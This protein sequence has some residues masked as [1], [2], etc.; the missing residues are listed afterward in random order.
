ME[1]LKRAYFKLKSIIIRIYSLITFILITLSKRKNQVIYI[2]AYPLGDTCYAL[3]YRSHLLNRNNCKFY[4]AESCRIMIENCFSDVIDNAAVVYYQKDSLLFKAIR[5]ALFCPWQNRF[6]SKL[7]VKII[8]PYAYLPSNREVIYD[9]F[10]ILK[11]I[12]FPFLPLNASIEFPLVPKVDINSIKDFQKNKKRIVILNPFSNS[13]CDDEKELWEMIADNLFLR[14]YIVYTNVM[15]HQKEVK[16]TKRLECSIIEL[17]NICNEI[18]LFVSVRSGIIDFTISSRCDKVVIW[19]MDSS[20]S[21]KSLKNICN[22]D[23][24]GITNVYSIYHI[25]KQDTIYGFNKYMECF[26][27]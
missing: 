22:L 15:K 10:T 3:A 16:D 17:Y 5:E 19:Y 23:A 12:I 21:L 11:K 9:Y 6:F 4:F 2:C 24:W 18:P 26:A 7:G 1:I 25:N 27:K 13:M 20:I 8:F 14:G